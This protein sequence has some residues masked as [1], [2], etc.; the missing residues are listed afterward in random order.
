ME[1]AYATVLAWAMRRR[2]FTILIALLVIA[3]SV[4]LYHVVRQEYVP[5]NVDQGEFEVYVN[6]PEGTSLAAMAFARCSRR[7]AAAGSSAA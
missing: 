1:N 6:A 4:P 2:G 5:S 3:S 7:P